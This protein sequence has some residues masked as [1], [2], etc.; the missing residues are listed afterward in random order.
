MI[1][2]SLI[3]ASA[4]AV[5]IAAASAP[6]SAKVNVDVYLGGYDPGYYEPAYPVYEEPRYRPRYERRYYGISCEAGRQEVRSAGFRKV[7]ALDCGGRSYA[8][9]A[10]RNGE[11]YIVEVSRRSGDIISVE[12]AY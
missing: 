6:A 11:T 8:Y 9:R 4:V 10:R 2:K 7:R 5:T 1:L 3:A 12:P